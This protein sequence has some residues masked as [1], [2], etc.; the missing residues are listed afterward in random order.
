[1]RVPVTVKNYARVSCGKVDAHTTS[2]SA[3]KEDKVSVVRVVPR[4]AFTSGFLRVEHVHLPL[5]LIN[6]C[7]SIDTTILPLSVQEVVLYDVQETRH[8][9]EDEDLM[10]ILVE[11]IKHAVQKSELSR[12]AYKQLGVSASQVRTRSRIDR[13]SEH[14]GVIAVLAVVHLLVR[15]AKRSG[16]LDPLIEEYIPQHTLFNHL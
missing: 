12:R 7:R 10:L 15:L 2:A 9:A 5:T 14:E 13:L 6:I 1:M 11:A 8:L 4:A 16:R 3:Q